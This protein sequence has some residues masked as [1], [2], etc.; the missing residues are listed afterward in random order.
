MKRL[1]YFFTLICISICVNA[2]FAQNAVSDNSNKAEHTEAYTLLE[3]QELKVNE[4]LTNLLKDYTAG[5]SA[6]QNKQFEL[7][8]TRLE[9]AKVLL[10]EPNK[11]YLLNKTYGNL[12]LNKIS[13]E[14]EMKNL[15]SNYTSQ[16]GKVMEKLPE[17]ISTERKMTDYLR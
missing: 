6:V 10:V 2:T 5:F 8:I 14:V 9:K 3:T 11:F 4:E 15:L 13:L 16:H 17:L 12:V 7:D 1:M